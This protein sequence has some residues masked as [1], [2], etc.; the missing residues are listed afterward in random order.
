M[1]DFLTKISN[2]IIGPMIL[3]TFFPV[4][5][6]VAA[7]AL[8]VLPLAPFG[9]PWT[10]VVA[11]PTDWQKNGI[12]VLEITFLVL[13]LSVVLYNLNSP[14]VRM[15]EGYPWRHSYIGKLL[16]KR[17]QSKLERAS[18]IRRCIGKLWVE[19]RIRSTN[20]DLGILLDV[21]T[22]MARLVN[23]DY[24]DRPGLVL[25]TRLGNVI[26]AFETYTTR[27]YGA[28]AISLWPRLA[29]V[30]ESS[31][32]QTLDNAKMAFDFMINS[33]F[34]TLVLAGMSTAAGLVWKPPVAAALYQAWLAW[35]LVFLVLSYLSYL[36]AINRAREWGTQVKSAF[37]LYRLSLFTK[38]GYDKPVDLAEERRMWEVINYKFAFPDERTYPDLPYGTP[39]TLLI[40]DP[41]STMLT[42]ERTVLLLDSGIIQIRILVVN[43]DPTR[44]PAGRAV[45]QDKIPNGK[46]YV[47][48][49]G[50]VNGAPA[51]ICSL[52]PIQIDLGPV[53]YY[54][55]RTVVYSINSQPAGA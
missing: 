54:E 28:G 13:V 33:S 22:N 40:V 7:F 45:L 10:G 1:T 36:A 21:Q 50:T 35:A 55:T 30:L 31:F 2:Q 52:N 29:G 44:A 47:R 51:T 11:N 46:A 41:V 53:P 38:L 4:V 8:V 9:Q 25:P 43:S 39:A 18:L 6:F 17:Q 27:Q 16:Q 3:S 37:D 49:S 12:A 15:Y 34:L 42:F 48:G 19:R 20:A 23:D 26:R 14:I 5:L 32:V 24:P